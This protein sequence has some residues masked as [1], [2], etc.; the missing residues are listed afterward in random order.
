LNV[1]LEQ[2]E[3]IIWKKLRCRIRLKRKVSESWKV[4]N[5]NSN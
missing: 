5:E 1:I 2:F 3:V 4:Q